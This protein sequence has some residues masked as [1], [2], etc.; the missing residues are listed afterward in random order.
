MFNP[1]TGSICILFSY[2]ELKAYRDMSTSEKSSMILSRIVGERYAED[3]VNGNEV[4][5]EE[6]L[7]SSLQSQPQ[8]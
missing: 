2:I 3:V 7:P 4:V 8:S 6:Q 5:A 1:K